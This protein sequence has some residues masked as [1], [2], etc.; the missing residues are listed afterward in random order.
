MGKTIESPSKKWTGSVVLSDPLTLPQALAWEKCI[1][2]ARNLEGE[3]TIT[4]INN[5]MLPG[6]L[7][8]V[9]TW[10]LEGLDPNKF[11]ASPRKQSRDLITWLINEI[12][13]IYM[14]EEEK[15]NPNE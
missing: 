11:P 5:A 8:C 14:G 2:N 12:T 15:A 10:E 6:I 4:D 7:A 1:R 13:R 3:I 9:E